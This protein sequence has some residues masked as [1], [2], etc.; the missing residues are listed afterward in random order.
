[1]SWL[2]VGGVASTSS[3]SE[4]SMVTW[5]FVARFFW[6]VAA[7]GAHF[8]CRCLVNFLV[9]CVP[10]WWLAL[11]CAIFGWFAE[12]PCFRLRLVTSL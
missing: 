8:W 1:M 12:V 11:R 7:T 3:A 9:V 4:V 5:G 2:L 6:S 10:L